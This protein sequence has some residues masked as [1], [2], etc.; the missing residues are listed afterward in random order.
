VGGRRTALRRRTMLW[1]VRLILRTQ[2]ASHVREAPR[3]GRETQS[4]AQEDAL[5]TREPAGFRHLYLY[6]AA[7]M[8]G[9]IFCETPMRSFGEISSVFNLSLGIWSGL[10][11]L[12]ALGSGWISFR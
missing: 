9:A 5:Y 12:M 1:L 4:R 2:G 8:S 11:R 7:T 10:P 3:E 6:R